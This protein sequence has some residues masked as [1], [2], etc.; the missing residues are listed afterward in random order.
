[1]NKLAFAGLTLIAGV[2]SASAGFITVQPVP[3]AGTTGLFLGIA[4]VALIALGRK[5]APKI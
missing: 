1:M 4:L 3:E 5:F 2:G